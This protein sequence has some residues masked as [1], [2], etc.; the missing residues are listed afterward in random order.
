[1][2]HQKILVA[3]VIHLYHSFLKQNETEMHKNFAMYTINLSN[4]PLLQFTI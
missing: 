1:M 3:L 2:H 4:E